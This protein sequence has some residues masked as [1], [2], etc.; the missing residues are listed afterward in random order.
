[1][2]SISRLVDMNIHPYLI[3]NT[4][5]LSVAQR[6]VRILCPCCKQPI[7][8]GDEFTKM[9]LPDVECYYRPVGCEECFYTGYKGRK[10][11]YEVIP[12]DNELSNAIR[13]SKDE[14]ECECKKEG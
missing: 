1:M 11:I 14:I 12:I 13:E 10:A 5:I 9:N 8:P 4:L 2:G 7:E 6:L 3:S